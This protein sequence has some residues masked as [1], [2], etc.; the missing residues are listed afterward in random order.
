MR[1]DRPEDPKG[2]GIG[3]F[4]DESYEWE[5]LSGDLQAGM[6]V[7]IFGFPVIAACA[8][9]VGL[10]PSLAL[11]SAV[12][13]AL[14]GAL[15]G[16]SHLQLLAPGLVALPILCPV[17]AEFGL[18]G[19]LLCGLLVGGMLLLLAAAR[20]G[21]LFLGFPP[22]ALAGLRLGIAA[23]IARWTLTHGFSYL[24]RAMGRFEACI[25]IG[26]LVAL[27]LPRLFRKG[28]PGIPKVIQGIPAAL[29]VLPLTGWVASRLAQGH[30]VATLA[31]QFPDSMSLGAFLGNLGAKGSW[32]VLA[33]HRLPEIF[34]WALS[35]TFLFALEAADDAETAQALTGRKSHLDLDLTTTGIANGLSVA[36]GGLPCSGQ[37]ERTLLNYLAG[38]R[39]PVAGLSFAAALGTVGFLILP[40]AGGVPVA[41]IGALLLTSAWDLSDPFSLT[42]RLGSASWRGRF[43]FLAGFLPIVA[44]NTGPALVIMVLSSTVLQAK[45]YSDLER[46]PEVGKEA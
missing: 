24:P 36:T 23:W 46:V 44:M 35:L 21:R 31:S 33:L 26:T 39:T 13:G 34:P 19:L 27:C 15:L 38:G 8:L 4:L 42:R 25:G 22:L 37:V 6:V 28:V 17:R 29:V 12:L 18:R 45:A 2:H 32:G 40:I 3:R 7:G 9:A 20:L 1:E 14:C 11:G 41:S 10:P 5:N 43:M 30:A 16:S